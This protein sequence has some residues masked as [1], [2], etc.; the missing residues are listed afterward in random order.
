MDKTPVRQLVLLGDFGSTYSKFQLIDE[1]NAKRLA[2][3]TLPT[4]QATSIVDCYQ[5]AKTQLLQQVAYR[6]NDD[7]LKEAFSSSAWG[8]FK[9]VVIGL[10]ASLTTRAAKQAAMGS[11]TRILAQ[12]AYRLT[13]GDWQEIT[14]LDPDAILLTGGTDGGDQRFVLTVASQLVNHSITA[15]VIYAGNRA[16]QDELRVLFQRQNKTLYLADNVMP[17]VNVLQMDGVKRV[18]AAIFNEKIV[19]SKGLDQV[20]QHAFLPIIPTP[21]AVQLATALL[22]KYF[23]SGILTIDV[24]GATT[25]VHTFGQGRPTAVNVLYEGLPEPVLKRTVEG[26]LGMRESAKSVV[27][28]YPEETLLAELGTGWDEASLFKQIAWRKKNHQALPQTAADRKL[29]EL[30]ALK[31]TDIALNRHLGQLTKRDSETWVQTG[32]DASHFQAVVATGGAL[33]HAVSPRQLY[34]CVCRETAAGTRPKHPALF[35]DKDYLLAAAGILS[36]YQ[37]AV[38]ER[39]LLGHLYK[40]SVDWSP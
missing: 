21:V 9:L 35:L 16:V 14:R 15:P 17:K 39:L 7:A 3:V 12:Y 25:D 27:A 10:T 1:T 28:Q 5:T 38:A 32:K 36:Q 34:R 19:T 20:A 18:A 30:L 24:G 26:D 31:A 33:L 8:G 11:G 22:G 23:G 37:P 4:T 29:E 40:E 13:E 6:P 2:H